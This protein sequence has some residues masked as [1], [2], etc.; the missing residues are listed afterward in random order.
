MMIVQRLCF[1]LSMLVT[2]VAS[3]GDAYATRVALV[4]GNSSYE[5]VAPLP[6]P[7]RDA[8][9]IAVALERLGF[10]VSIGRDTKKGA[11]E[12]LLADFSEKAAQAEIAV[13]FYA[14]HGIEVGGENYLI[15]VDAKLKSDARIK[16]ETVSLNDILSALESGNGIKL[17]LLDACRNNPFIASMSGARTRSIGRGLARVE[18]ADGIYISY[19]AAAGTTASD[20]EGEHS[21]YT[22]A[23]LAT[24]EQPGLEL[25]FLFRKVARLVKQ[26]TNGAQ[27]PF[28]YGRLPDVSVYLK[29]PTQKPLQSAENGCSDA[30][31]HWAAIENKN[32]AAL[33]EAHLQ[34][35]GQCAFAELARDALNRLANEKKEQEVHASAN[36]LNPMPP[37]GRGESESG[38][39]SSVGP[40]MTDGKPMETA[41]AL[42]RTDIAQTDL[43]SL[44][45]DVQRGLA[46]LG[47]DAGDADGRWG[48]QS[49]R[50]MERFNKFSKLSLDVGAPSPAA[51]EAINIRSGRIC[52]L[53]CAVTEVAVD[54]HCERKSCGSGLSLNE[55]GKCVAPSMGG[56]QGER[57]KEGL[58]TESAGQ[59]SG[60][61]DCFELAGQKFC[62]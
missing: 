46:R 23:L 54:D 20:G 33:F 24:I 8:D 36:M 62:M 31:A 17:V 6:N 37:L 43:L 58:K 61:G 29:P 25:N 19:A 41:V 56:T 11:L 60:A 48:K 45:Q 9:A 52:P 1:L 5:A 21:P 14:G 2:I 49:Q 57:R 16:F 38:E 40:G 27:T 55:A 10:E 32:T 12:R 42:P 44:A 30:A 22:E 15:P 34:H 7:A 53:E 13:V 28:E 47:C 26:K 4:I 59:K 39:D 35:F 18:A 50:A 3:T 51:L